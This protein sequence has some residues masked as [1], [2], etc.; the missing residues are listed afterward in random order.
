MI[1]F[2]VYDFEVVISHFSLLTSQLSTVVIPPP[3]FAVLPLSGGRIGDVT[4]GV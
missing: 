4:T 2:L 3:R 1:V